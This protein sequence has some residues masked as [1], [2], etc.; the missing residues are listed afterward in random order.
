MSAIDTKLS[1]S[2]EKAVNETAEKDLSGGLDASYTAFD[3]WVNGGTG[4]SGNNGVIT[5][6]D[7]PGGSILDGVLYSNR[8]SQSDEKY[9]GFG[10]LTAMERALELEE[11][12]G[13]IC[14]ENR[15]RPE[16]AVNPDGSTATRSLCRK[17]ELDTNSRNDWYIVPTRHASF[18]KENSEEEYVP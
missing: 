16:D 2:R 4:L 6:L 3:F 15:V 13:W 7:R 9:L 10:T 8:T 14:E 11:M 18:G 1:K 12:K 5:L 17:R